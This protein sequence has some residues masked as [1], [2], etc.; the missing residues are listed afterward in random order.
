MVIH[1]FG[2]YI[3]TYKAVDN[4][5]NEATK[6]RIVKVAPTITNETTDAITTNSITVTW[7]TDHPTTSRVIYDVVSHPTLNVA[8]NYGYAN[9]TVEDSTLVT[10]HNVTVNNLT[11]GTNY[12]FRTVSH[13]SPETVSAE[14]TKTTSASV[15]VVV[16]VADLF[17]LTQILVQ[18][19]SQS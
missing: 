6:N 18:L 10:N 9:S 11:A 5:G 1:N 4:A 3:I 17:L 16:E 14:F 7:T 13:G 19:T 12:F 8:P 15:S 2:E